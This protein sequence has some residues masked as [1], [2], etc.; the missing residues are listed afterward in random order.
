MVD[1]CP[2]KGVMLMYVTYEALIALG[3]LI[4]AVITLI[5]TIKRK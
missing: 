3:T 4:V 2:R 1:G 5:I